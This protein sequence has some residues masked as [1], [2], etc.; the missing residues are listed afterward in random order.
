MKFDFCKIRYPRHLAGICHVSI[1]IKLFGHFVFSVFQAFLNFLGIDHFVRFA[2]D[3][4]LDSSFG[5]NNVHRLYLLI[6]L[7]RAGTASFTALLKG[8]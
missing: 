3:G 8:L 7:G 2:F 5:I 4:E 6:L 1:V